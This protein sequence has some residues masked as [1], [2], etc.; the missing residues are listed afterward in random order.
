MLG[1]WT[2]NSTGGYIRSKLNENINEEW[3]KNPVGISVPEYKFALKART[4]ILPV[5]FNLKKWGYG[6]GNC[7]LCGELETVHHALQGCNRL[8]QETNERHN[9]V[10]EILRKYIPQFR[11]G[12][13]IQGLIP[14]GIIPAEANKERIMVD[15]TICGESQEGASTDK[16]QIEKQNKYSSIK[17]CRLWPIIISYTGLVHPNLLSDTINITGIDSKQAKRM[18]IEMK[19]EVIKGSHKI[20]LT[21]N[22]K[23]AAIMK[24]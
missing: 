17:D 1:T 10:L 18:I 14:D 24:N 2:H 16:A 8:T 12:E 7:P 5:G 9:R 3:I 19:N 6:N 23:K 21:R 11:K 4:R 13:E 22:K 15:V 20:W